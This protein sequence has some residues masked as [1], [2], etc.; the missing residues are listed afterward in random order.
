MK[1][2]RPGYVSKPIHHSIKVFTQARKKRTSERRADFSICHQTPRPACNMN[3][4]CRNV[5]AGF[6][7]PILFRYLCIHDEQ[8]E[9]K[10]ETVRLDYCHAPVGFFRFSHAHL[11]DVGNALL[12]PGTWPIDRGLALR[13]FMPATACPGSCRRQHGER[14]F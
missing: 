5:H 13:P 11:G 3:T 9:Q 12:R 7:S 14:L 4:K 10:K 2:N 6:G 1:T 8:R